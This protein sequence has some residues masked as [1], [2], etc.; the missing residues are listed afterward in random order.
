MVAVLEIPTHRPPA[1]PLPSPGARQSA[2][3]ALDCPFCL[4]TF[5]TDERSF[6]ADAF[7]CPSC[8]AVVEWAFLPV[9]EPAA[10]RLPGAA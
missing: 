3:V 8:R 5:V 9:A 10:I 6:R 1:V 4:D 2:P 7:A